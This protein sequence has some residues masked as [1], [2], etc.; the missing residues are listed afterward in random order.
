MRPRLGAHMSIAGGV[1]KA[2]QRGAQVGCETVAIF[3]KSPNRWAPRR[4]SAEEIARFKQLEA[5]T[6]IS[7]VFA[8]DSY[9]VNVGS[10][11]PDLWEKSVADL[12]EEL[13]YCEALGL[14][15]LVMHPGAH[16]GAG[17]EQGLRNIM[18]ALDTVH[19]RTPGYR[20]RILL[21][22]T[23]GQGT[24]LGG[25]FEEL[26]A[27]LAGVKAPERLGVC[28]DTCHVFAAGYELRTRE[29]YE[30]TMQALDRTVGLA[31]V[32]AFHLNDSVGG[33]G[34]HL[35]RHAEIG[36]GQLGL[37]AFRWLLNDPRWGGRPM[38]LE[39]DYAPDIHE[40]EENLGRLRALEEMEE[41]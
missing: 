24:V 30:A 22:T 11:K 1:D 19:E 5:E 21:E 14:P 4:L 34:E 25:R 28:F 23:A 7:P 37:D 16:D 8:H 9:L 40:V 18:R 35:D 38:V 20:A 32:Q 2:V 27:L 3:V 36:A 6:G 41:N 26:Q 13:G 31:R 29:G 33:L 39:L 15:F 12:V 17:V 10:P